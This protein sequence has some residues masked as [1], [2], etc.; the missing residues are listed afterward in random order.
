MKAEHTQ[1]GGSSVINRWRWN[2]CPQNVG[3]SYFND[4]IG[5]TALDVIEYMVL[6]LA[7]ESV[8]LRQYH[9]PQCRLHHLAKRQFTKQFPTA[10]ETLTLQPYAWFDS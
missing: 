4:M 8:S 3:R 1:S 10:C 7:N 6:Q 5:I 9:M 2:Q